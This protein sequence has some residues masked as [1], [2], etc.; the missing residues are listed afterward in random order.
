MNNVDF[1]AVDT[2]ILKQEDAL[3]FEHF[4]NRDAWELGKLM[5]EEALLNGV[6]IAI[7]IRKMNGNILFQYA[8]EKTTINNQNWMM[9]KFNT[10]S[11]M[12]RSSLGAAVTSHITG[13]TVATHG[14]SDKD[15][16]FCG[17]GFPVRIKNSGLTAVITVSNLPHVQDHNYIIRCLSKYLGAD[18]PEVDA[19][20]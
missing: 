12:E 17:G 14:L 11:L 15:F 2:L 8:T 18:V 9:R 13:E 4:N 19:E 3:Q 1:P 7:C 10:V 5:V 6:E 16:V 20:F